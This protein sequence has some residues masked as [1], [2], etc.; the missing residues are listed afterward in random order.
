ML[1]L[2]PLFLIWGSF[3][4][5]IAY[6]LVNDISFKKHR[7]FCPK[8]NK[9]LSWYDLI[10]IV[11]WLF[12]RGS[13]RNCNASISFL[14][15]AIELFSA[16]SFY[17]LFLNIPFPYSIS[18]FVF[19]SALIITIRTDIETMLI[20]RY[21]TL[22][23][24]PLALAF[25]LFDLLPIAPMTMLFGTLFG[26]FLLFFISKTFFLFTK[27]E[28]IGQGDIELLALIGAFTGIMGCWISLL[29]GSILGSVFGIILILLQHLNFQTRIPFGPFLA[30]GSMIYVLYQD[31]ILYLFFGI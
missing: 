25:S 10:P 16:I 6:R 1:F 4:N 12:L 8:C 24:V 19:F 15:P 28:G 23:L 2:I 5:V 31:Y 18:Y 3:L 11:S 21:V 29:L 30:L 14:Y 20:S 17:L 7:S 22:F 27:K 9:I 26:Y 13:C